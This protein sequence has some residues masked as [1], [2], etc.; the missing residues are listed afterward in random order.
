[1]Y[2]GG[3]VLT[4]QSGP[5]AG[6]IAQ[7]TLLAALGTTV[8]LSRSGWAVGLACGVLTNTGV[9]RGLARQARALGPA[10]LVTLTRVT[11]AGGVAALVADA[12]FREP[13][14][15]PLLALTVAALM[16]DAVDGW[17]ARRTRSASTFGARFDGEADAFLILV[18]SVYVAR[19]AGGWVLAIGAARY[20]FLVAGWGM[21]WMRAQLPPRYWRKVVA[22][23]QGIVLTV[24]AADVVPHPLAY[25]ALGAALALL[26]ES[27]GRDILWL[28]RHRRGEV[29]PPADS[30]ARP[31][32]GLSVQVRSHAGEDLPR[33]R[34]RRTGAVTAAATPAPAALHV[35]SALIVSNHASRLASAFRSA[36]ASRWASAFRW[37]SRAPR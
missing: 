33:G 20:V 25:A 16:L 23:T 9:A 5:A 18:L 10:D 28:W 27:F 19:S 2:T 8:G 21:P 35:W 15:E 4:V 29:A 1:M 36:G 34:G 26:A 22:A 37:G 30:V 17:V 11:L 7:V 12:F 3:A 32:N 13:A 14:V 6:A 31:H 24:V